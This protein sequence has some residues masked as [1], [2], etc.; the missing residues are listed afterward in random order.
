MNNQTLNNNNGNNNTHIQVVCLIS[1]LY[2][3]S[4]AANLLNID[5]SSLQELISRG[6]I[7]SLNVNAQPHFREND[8]WDWM[9]KQNPIMIKNENPELDIFAN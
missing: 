5:E 6:E 7:S 3:L 9:Y 2:N 1:K 8:L 4:E